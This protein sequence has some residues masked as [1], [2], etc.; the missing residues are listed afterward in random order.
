MR[1]CCLETSPLFR[2]E[3]GENQGWP[4]SEKEWFQ[5]VFRYFSVYHS[6]MLQHCDVQ[7]KNNSEC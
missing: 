2:Q 6:S 7:E 3:P 5:L 1:G 4:T